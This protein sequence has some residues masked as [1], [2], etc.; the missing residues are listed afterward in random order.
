[1]PDNP[2]PSAE[3]PI[4]TRRPVILRVDYMGEAPSADALLPAGA[5][6]VRIHAR[7]APEAGTRPHR[8]FERPRLSGLRP[9]DGGPAKR[10]FTSSQSSQTQGAEQE[11]GE[12]VVELPRTRYRFGAALAG[13]RSPGPPPNPCL[14]GVSANP[15]RAAAGLLRGIATATR[16]VASQYA[17]RSSG[18]AAAASPPIPKSSPGTTREED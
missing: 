3:R 5:D 17:N 13:G 1:M 9:D 16:T 2:D 10:V 18:H 4:Q 6:P 14:T 12:L 7:P 11:E 8:P 15:I